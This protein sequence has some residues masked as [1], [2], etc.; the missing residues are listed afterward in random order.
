M[1]R[2]PARTGPG[3][4]APP[5]GGPEHPRGRCIMEVRV[6]DGPRSIEPFGLTNSVPVLARP[7]A[8]RLPADRAERVASLI[9]SYWSTFSHGQHQAAE[10]AHPAEREG[11]D[12]E[13]RG[14]VVPEDRR[15]QVPR[16]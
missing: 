11:P 9:E 6:S 3:S 15:P 7:T 5:S 8:D 4:G 2:C 10:E 14:P 13:P 1:N 16:G 12:P